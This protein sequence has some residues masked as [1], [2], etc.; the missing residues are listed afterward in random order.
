[1]YIFLILVLEVLLEDET[2]CLSS[3]HCRGQNVTHMQFPFFVDTLLVFQQN[4]H[5]LHIFLI[6]GV[7]QGVFG[8]NLRRQKNTSF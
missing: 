8:L 1:M 4:L 5:R 6:D 2:K 3:R 7:Q